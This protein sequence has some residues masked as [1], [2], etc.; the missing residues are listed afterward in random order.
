[1]LLLRLMRG[2]EVA[3]SISRSDAVSFYSSSYLLSTSPN[4]SSSSRGWMSN[5]RF[6]NREDCFRS[7]L[8]F[9]LVHQLLQANWHH[10]SAVN[11]YLYSSNSNVDL[12]RSKLL[13]QSFSIIMKDERFVNSKKQKRSKTDRCKAGVCQINLNNGKKNTVW[14]AV[15][16]VNHKISHSTVISK[17]SSAIYYEKQ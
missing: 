15:S 13:V 2:T 17:M 3:F 11:Q 7:A 6:Q 4:L 10:F 1:M 14:A 12:L 9:G 8:K 5:F 16:K